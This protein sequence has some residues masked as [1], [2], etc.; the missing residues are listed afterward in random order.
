MKRV[1]YALAAGI[2][3]ISLGA[4]VLAH[5]GEMHGGEQAQM[6]TV[7]GEVIDLVCYIDHGAVGEK[8]LSCAKTCIESGLP[9]GIKGTD[10]KTYM[11]VGEHKPINQ[12]LAPLAAK[13]ITV[14]GKLVSRDGF[15]LL[16][17]VEIVK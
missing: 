16:E 15:N 3:A 7:T 6:V 10:G 12:A 8:H 11:V 9:V 4:T 17:N 5:E 1:G 2:I 13:T 14:R